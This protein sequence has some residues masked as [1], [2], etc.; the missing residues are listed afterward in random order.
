MSTSGP[1]SSGETPSRRQ[2]PD[3]GPGIPAGRIRQNSRRRARHNQLRGGTVSRRGAGTPCPPME[4][5][6]ST[7]N[8]P[9][10]G[11]H[12]IS[13]PDFMPRKQLAAIQLQRLQSV[14]ARAYDRVPLMR[15]RLDERGLTPASVTSLDDI[16]RLPF[17]VKTD[18][19]DT[20]P[21][22]LFA[23]PME[24]IVRL[25]ASSGTTGKP[26]V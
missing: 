24:E 22:G 12:P 3:T 4:A 26:I 19:R 2:R 15:T 25:H 14:V 9:P 1:S 10:G 7:W 18:L 16:A 11:F 17:T 21:F 23:S 8:D 6:V 5:V 13:A 20:Y